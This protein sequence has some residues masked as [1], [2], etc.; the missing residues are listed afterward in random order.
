MGS[1]FRKDFPSL[2]PPDPR[3]CRELCSCVTPK[4]KKNSSTSH[5]DFTNVRITIITI[6]KPSLWLKMKGNM[7]KKTGP[8]LLPS[9][10]SW[11][12]QQKHRTS[13]KTKT[14]PHQKL[15]NL[16]IQNDSTIHLKLSFATS[17]AT[18]FRNSMEKISCF[19]LLQGCWKNSSSQVPKCHPVRPVSSLRNTGVFESPGGQSLKDK[20]RSKG[21]YNNFRL[22]G[23]SPSSTF[24]GT[25]IKNHPP[26]VISDSNFKRN[27]GCPKSF[28]TSGNPLGRNKHS[29]L[30]IFYPF[31]PLLRLPLPCRRHHSHVQQAS[32]MGVLPPTLSQDAGRGR[33]R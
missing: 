20:P 27:V 6:M 14:G 22:F 19:W 5:L 23:R 21:D 11:V 25:K 1:H 28:V 18:L 8:Q 10:F 17:L 13:H 9:S 32:R 7:P 4:K 29:E 33:A 26:E 30:P 3:F 31:G 15:R 16:S 24:W 2:Q 12:P